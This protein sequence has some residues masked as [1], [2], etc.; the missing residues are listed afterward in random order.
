MLALHRTVSLRYLR[1]RWSRAV[2]I[3]VSIA[4]GVAAWVGT[5][6]TYENLEYS[7]RLAANPFAGLADLHISN[8]SVGVPRSLEPV[9]AGVPGVRAVHPLLIEQVQVVLADHRRQPALL[10]G[11][12][13]TKQAQSS[14]NFLLDQGQRIGSARI[15]DRLA[16]RPET[17]ADRRRP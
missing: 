2:L 17:R 6:A 5:G 10:L 14:G 9:L 7:I 8:G 12:D 13:L 4:L 16:I 1:L 11:L 15:P 3:M